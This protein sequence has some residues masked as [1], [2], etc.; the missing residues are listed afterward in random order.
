MVGVVAPDF[1]RELLW[2]GASFHRDM[3]VNASP[4]CFPTPAPLPPVIA[5]V[6]GPGQ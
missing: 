6:A 3:V 4:R 2:S 5:R 1:V